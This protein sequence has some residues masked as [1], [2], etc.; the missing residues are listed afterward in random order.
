M[1]D[2]VNILE[3]GD[4]GKSSGKSKIT[5]VNKVRSMVIITA[6]LIIFLS[7][8]C[9]VVSIQKALKNDTK[10]SITNSSS[11][12]AQYVDAWINQKANSTEAMAASAVVFS[13]AY[14]GPAEIPDDVLYDWLADCLEEDSDVLTYYLAKEA[15]M[16]MPGSDGKN[17]DV[18][19]TERGWW[20]EA[21]EAGE[22][23]ITAP[24]IDANTGAVVISI[25]TPVYLDGTRAA[26][27]ADVTLDSLIANISDVEGTDMEI[28]LTTDDGTIITYSNEDYC[29]DTEGNSYLITDACDIDLDADEMQTY[30]DEDGNSRFAVMSTVEY[31]GWILA[32]TQSV[33]QMR[34]RE[35]KAIFFIGICALII[36]II[37]IIYLTSSVRKMLAPMGA[38]K[39]F[40]V[41]G[42]V[43]DANVPEFKMETEEISYLIGEMEVSFVGTIRD[44]R[45]GMS[46]ISESVTSTTEAV[47][48]ISGAIREISSLVH[49]IADNLNTQTENLSEMTEACNY[50]SDKTVAVGQNTADMSERATSIQAKIDEMVPRIM[51]NKDATVFASTDTA[52]KLTDAIRDAECITEITS[53]SDA[54]QEIASQTN[55]L[56][57]NASIEAAR[58]GESGKGFAVVADEIRALS[59]STSEEIGKINELASKLLTSVKILSSESGKIVDLITTKVVHDYESMEDIAKNYKDDATYYEQTSGSLQQEFTKL[60]D[61]IQQVTETIED[62]VASQEELNASME[63]TSSSLDV[64]AQN[65]ENVKT[66][67]IDMSQTVT[68]VR[69]TVNRFN[70][71]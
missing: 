51:A 35:V 13:E 16:K 9:A 33:S 14:G 20:I 52:Q 46:E 63:A 42:I 6:I 60:H 43:G 30:T 22:T 11:D 17:L 50:I 65:T 23:I 59:D 28:F 19:I 48:E 29:M 5:I 54:I 53:I 68:D 25:A 31:S 62:L 2:N 39:D 56:S 36:A 61:S 41:H 24:Y 15:D 71:E 55:L 67:S 57:L 37:S 70:V 26:V 69:S 40:I 21:W 45:S 12:M 47:D 27:L 34:A 3:M 7:V 32:A 58:A 38:L 49:D 44:T 10:T 4:K 18:V 66:S 64:V 1:N 8:L